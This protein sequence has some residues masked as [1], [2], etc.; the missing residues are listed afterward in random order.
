MLTYEYFASLFCGNRELIEKC[1]VLL[2]EDR[3]PHA[4][5]IDGDDGLGKSTFARIIAQAL[6]CTCP[7]VLEG[8]C[9]HCKKARENIH[10]DIITVTGTG[11]SGNIPVDSIRALHEDTI[12]APNEADKKVYIIEDCEGLGVQSQNALLKMFEEPPAGVFFILT[13]RSAMSLLTTIRSRAQI[14]SLQSVELSEAVKRVAAL[15]PKAGNDAVLSAVSRSG[16]NIGAALALI[17]ENGECAASEWDEKASAAAMALCAENEQEL[18]GVC[19]SLGADRTFCA[20]VIDSMQQ[21]IRLAVVISVG[22][23]PDAAGSDAQ[24]LAHS[25]STERLYN[26]NSELDVLKRALSANLDARSLFPAAM[27]ARLRRAA[28]K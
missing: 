16:G 20:R 10:P 2:S 21:I 8:Q 15:R 18:L 3:F 13:C 12:V 11:K 1:S 24:A 22:G 17:G 14:F 25:F 4:V 7:T 26:I 9:T 27:C 6:L 28:G 23:S 5:I 19:C